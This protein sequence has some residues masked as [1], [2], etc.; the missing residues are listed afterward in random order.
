MLW[1]SKSASVPDAI[2]VAAHTVHTSASSCVHG[3]EQIGV[4]ARPTKSS[5]LYKT[6]GECP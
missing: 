3:Y 6:A 1:V 5:D 2:G 4:Q